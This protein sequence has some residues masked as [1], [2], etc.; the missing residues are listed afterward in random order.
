MRKAR[1]RR[2]AQR[3]SAGGRVQRGED[4]QKDGGIDQVIDV[5]ERQTFPQASEVLI[6]TEKKE[7]RDAL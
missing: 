5:H 7:G 6:G 2:P 3:G 4:R 1:E